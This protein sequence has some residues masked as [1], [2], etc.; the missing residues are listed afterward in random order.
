M[1][2]INFLK[3]GKSVLSFCRGVASRR[4]GSTGFNIFPSVLK[5]N[6]QNQL[7][8]FTSFFNEEQLL[9]KRIC[10]SRSKFL[11]FKSRPY[12]IKKRNSQKLILLVKMVEGR[13]ITILELSLLEVH[14]FS[15]V[16]RKC[17][18]Q[19]NLGLATPLF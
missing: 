16:A 11:Y 3:F 18:L 19:Q 7:C 9:Q 13:K 15:Y 12:L 2:H 17:L 1:N 14:I 5:L 8:I 6:V 10:S 4:A